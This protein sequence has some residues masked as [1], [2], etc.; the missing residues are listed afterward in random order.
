VREALF[1]ILG[2]VSG[3]RV[4]D[5]FAGTGALALEALSRGATTAVLVDGAAAAVRCAEENA[6]AL[7]VE[8]RVRVVRSEVA[9]A[10]ARLRETF[11][12]VFLDP[13]YAAGVVE[14]ALAALPP[15]LAENAR[16]VV[17]H[18]RRSAPG[19]RIGPLARV[20]RR[21]YGDTEVSFYAMKA[22]PP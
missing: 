9:P 17:E 15:L 10:L 11:D 22:A 1:N 16:V 20:D 18:D 14:Q 2:D 19:D 6:A 8:A 5:L 21:R 13:P 4:L 3:A 12:L 7:G